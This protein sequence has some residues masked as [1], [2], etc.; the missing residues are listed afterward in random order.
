[1]INKK[2][3]HQKGF[4]LNTLSFSM[5]LLSGSVHALEVMNDAD[6]RAVNGQDGIQ[7]TATLDAAN[8][9]ALYWTDETGRGTTAPADKQKLTAIAQNVSIQKSNAS[10]I[11]AGADIKVNMGSEG[12]KT[13]MDLDVLLNPMLLKVGSFSVCDSD[14]ATNKCSA[15]LG[16]LAVQTASSTQFGLQTRDGLFSKTSQAGLNIGI[17]NANIYLGQ[18]DANN[19][20][21]QLVLRNMNFNFK[22]KGYMFVDAVNGF[23]MQTNNPSL[24]AGALLTTTPNSDYGYVDFN[25][26]TDPG[27]GIAGFVNKGTYVTGGQTTGSGLN[28]EIML[29]PNAN[30]TDPYKLDAATLS[31]TGAKGL[32]RVGA[33]GRMVNGSLQLRGLTTNGVTDALGKATNPSGTTTNNISGNSGIAFRMKADFTSD[34]DAMLATGTADAGQATTLEI[35][36]AGL[37]SYGFEFSNLTGLVQGTRGSF[38]SGNVYFNLIDTKSVLLPTNYMLLN[39]RFGNNSTL[40]TAADY[41][42][43]IHD[44]A[45]NPYAVLISLRG[46]EFQSIARRGRFTASAGVADTNLFSN[47]PNNGLDNQWGLG[48]PFYNLNANLAVYGTQVPANTVYYYTADGKQ[49]VVKN[50]AT[51]TSR[52]GFSLAMSTDGIDRDASNKALGNKTTSIL[53]IDGG[54]YKDSSGATKTTDYYMGLR[55]V[56]MLLKG[57][58]TIGVEKGSLNVGLKNMLIV[59]AGE[60]AAGYLPGTTYKSC[61]M[62]IAAYASACAIKKTADLKSFAS[63]DDVLFGAKLRIGGDM[64]FSL[65]PTNNLND[66]GQMSIVGD[67]TLASTGNT[68]QISDPVNGSIIGLDN[69][70]GK[71]GFINSIAISKDQTTGQTTSGFGQ[72][73]FNSSFTINPD[74]NQAGVLRARDINFYPPTSGVGARLGELA[75]T[76]GR[77]SSDFTIKPR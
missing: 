24:S 75:I 67:L 36:G 3:N 10:A 15:T 63:A 61:A 49:N 62:G 68:I 69:L 56:D 39:S 29:T 16:S 40:T 74:N 21:N 4:I 70:T 12:T 55:N 52:L 31:P 20:L 25:R 5:L 77:I 48:L 7:M 71:I 59:L 19:E 1:M 8:V 45:T 27:A 44:L 6:M 14:A 66:G 13:G 11:Q 41:T 65:L 32:I 60:V 23:M 28:L 38:D 46:A 17:Q 34:G 64:N 26:V 51:N 37:N 58:G 57:N 50:D 54:K 18:T 43:N 73:G 35:G 53:V 33:S 42:Q 9:D 72:V 2:Q 47:V 22:G 76:G 30:K